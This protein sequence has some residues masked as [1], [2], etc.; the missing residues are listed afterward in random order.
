MNDIKEIRVLSSL[1]GGVPCSNHDHGGLDVR[2][3]VVMPIGHTEDYFTLSWTE[4]DIA[5]DFTPVQLKI[6]MKVIT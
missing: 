1:T 5:K 4:V 6:C 2:I 3:S